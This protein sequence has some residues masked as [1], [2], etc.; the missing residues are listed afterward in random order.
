[1]EVLTF[2]DFFR[3]ASGHE[4]YAYQRRMAEA[5]AGAFPRVLKVPTGAGKTLAVVLA[6]LWRRRFHPDPKVRS[7]TPRRL[8][9]CLPTRVLVEQTRKVVESAVASL[10]L[11]WPGRDDPPTGRGDRAA[12]SVLVATL[13]GG[14]AETP[15]PQEE[16]RWRLY[17]EVDSVLIGTQDMLLSRALNRGF[18]TSRFMW[19]VEFGLVSNDALWVFDEVQLMG[20]GLATSAQL[21]AL[22]EDLGVV[23]PCRS[24]WLSATLDPQWLETVDHP[25]PTEAEV[26]SLGE[27]DLA[28][29][30]LAVRLLARKSLVRLLVAAP[31]QQSG[32][33]GYAA[34][35][36][37]QVLHRH[38]PGTLTLVIL[39]AVSRAKAVYRELLKAGGTSTGAPDWVLLHSHYRPPDR[40]KLVERALSPVPSEGRIVVSTQVVEAGV[41]ISA[42]LLVTELAPWASMVQRF[43][44]Y[45]RYGERN[46]AVVGWVNVPD[47]AAAPYEAAELTT[48][49]LNLSALATGSADAGISPEALASFGVSRPRMTYVL[50]R[51][52]LVGLF[53]TT[54]DLS[55]FDV[56]VSRY[57]RD[58]KDHDVQLFWRDWGVGEPPATLVTPVSVEL[59][60]V[61]IGEIRDYLAASRLWCWDHLA[62][63]WV[64]S[65]TVYP[66]LILL[67]RA[68]DGGYDPEVG[69]D[70]KAPGPV[71]VLVPATAPGSTA[72]VYWAAPSGEAGGQPEE[73]MGDDTD[74]M[75]GQ[76][77]VSIAEHTDATME[78]LV[79]L[80][81]KLGRRYLPETLREALVS[82]ARWHDRGKAHPVFQD[83]LL[84]RLPEA[85]RAGASAVLWA[86]TDC[87]PA[88]HR[89]KHFRHELAGA[90]AVLGDTAGV[91]R[92]HLPLV[93]YLVAAHHGRVRLAIRSFPDEQEPPGYPQQR[94]AAGVWEGDVLPE[95]DLGG[96]VK[97]PRMTIDLSPM[98]LGGG[99]PGGPS[100]LELTLALRDSPEFGPFRLA[101][102]EALVRA[103]DARASIAHRKGGIKK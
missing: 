102:L 88:H 76:G 92:G 61:P 78:T 4:P 32:V 3:R 9:Y 74:S 10:G 41:D 46:D 58:S 68:S 33:A 86:K 55:G 85:D 20:S 22:R 94:Y 67:A 100:W 25:A 6:W 17:P 52:D 79:G 19:P 62:G 37:R 72:G 82:A 15:G 75:R 90:L 56:D 2:K 83:T 89:R 40:A 21:E 95:V 16:R 91:A 96:D 8:L 64:R 87:G 57:V 27:G 60:P 28:D 12:Q 80:L 35:V 63:E 65:K 51:P 26:V 93:A 59:C 39:N 70:P 84:S 38:S 48:S 47:D 1:M 54:P 81:E 24:L 50:R 97:A 42:R 66:G 99:V 11:D 103:A 30:R 101:F 34:E 5:P 29:P 13:M 23:G 53:D 7:E 14:S 69:W 49:R 43:G 18:G 73:A 77:W 71:P 44:R 45:N 98:E 31:S 36:A